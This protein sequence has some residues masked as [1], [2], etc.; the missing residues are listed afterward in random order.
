MKYILYTSI[1]QKLTPLIAWPIYQVELRLFIEYQQYKLQLLF[2]KNNYNLL[3]KSRPTWK[4]LILTIK[5]ITN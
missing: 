3:L 4:I 5:M 1:R 2:D